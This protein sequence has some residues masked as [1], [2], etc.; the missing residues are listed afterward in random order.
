[1]I[2][3]KNTKLPKVCNLIPVLFNK[4]GAMY[5]FVWSM[6]KINT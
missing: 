1:M 5:M 6:K 3:N 4:R 2:L